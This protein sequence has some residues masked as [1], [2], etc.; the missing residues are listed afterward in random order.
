MNRN[1]IPAE[2][3]EQ[4]AEEQRRRLHNAAVELR[5]SVAESVR[6]KL[7]LKRYLREYIGP[8]TAVA[9]IF[10]LLAGYGAAGIFVRD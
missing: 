8:A 10:G 4:R 5:S 7:D 2:V 6:E 9:A 1:Q 3:L